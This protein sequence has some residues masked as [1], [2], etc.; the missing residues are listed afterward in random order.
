[1]SRASTTREARR[2]A[3]TITYER[4]P[5]TKYQLD[6]FFH[7]ERYGEIEASTK[8]GKT[9]GGIAWLNEEVIRIGAP[10]RNFWWVAPS[11]SQTE[12]AYR[13]I[14]LALPPG[15]C[16][17]NDTNLT[18]LFPNGARMWFKSGE[19]PDSLYGE[20]V[21]A[22]VIDEASR[23]R[24]D[25]FYA[26]RSTITKTKGK[27]RMIGNVK[28]RRNWF[29]QLCR[30]AESG[31]KGHVY[32]RITAGDAAKA[33]ILSKEEI[34]D[35]QRTL[36]ENIFKELFLAIPSDDGGNPFGQQHI[37]ECVAPLSHSQ[38]AVWGWDLAKSVDW[39]VG[40]ALDAQNVVCRF[41]RFQSPWK[42]TIQRIH[43]ETG[44]TVARIDSTGVGDPVL[45]QLQRGENAKSIQYEN[46]EGVL[47]SAKS[48]QQLMEGL[49]VGIQ[50]HN[51]K[52][53]EGPIVAELDSFEYEYTGRGGHST[54]VKYAA[55][56]GMH[57]DCVC[58]L[59][60][61]YMGASTAQEEPWS[62]WV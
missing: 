32:S 10:G 59:A 23:L 31:E 58:A 3:K 11:Y 49:A 25:A 50:Q 57:D 22:C 53:P 33:G 41:V 6:A 47:F 4:P 45:E 48:K 2:S 1:V 61:A 5:L 14:K 13:R 28:G 40:I 8:S 56:P 30:K 43:Q 7:A 24:A 42:E 52:F 17:S 21:Y 15:L 27:L 16:K 46:F 12:I 51:V 9:H 44:T 55:A 60:L 29:Y 62:K 35:A 54:G 34:D 39:T 26:I 18:I 38:P 20:D 36:P 37:Q 19:K